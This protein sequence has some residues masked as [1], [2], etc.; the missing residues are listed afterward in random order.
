MNLHLRRFTF[1]GCVQEEIMF[2][3]APD[4]I[5]GMVIC[6]TMLNNEGILIR[7]AERYSKHTGYGRGFQFD[8]NFEDSAPLYFSVVYFR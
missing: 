3:L 5:V 1:E 4:C 7:G 2:T 6:S 8:G